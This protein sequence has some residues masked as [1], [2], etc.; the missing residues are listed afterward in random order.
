MHDT[1]FLDSTGLH[2][3]NA[4][5]ANDLATMVK[6]AYEYPEIRKFSTLPGY[7]ISPIGSEQVLS[8]RNTNALVRNGEWEIG[9]SKTGFIKESGK[10]LIMYAKIANT[11]LVI[12]LL[13][14]WGKYTRLGDAARIKKWMEHRIE[15]KWRTS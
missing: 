9:L 14:S 12:V 8:Y 10:C 15:M 13:D 11:P 1:H 3:Q 4:S 5:T 2:S 6:T 7:E